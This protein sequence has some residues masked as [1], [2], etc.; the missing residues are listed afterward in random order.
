MCHTLC[1]A[2]GRATEALIHSVLLSPGCYSESMYPTKLH[3]YYG[4]SLLLGFGERAMVG[5]PPQLPALDQEEE[6]RSR[7]GPQVIHFIGPWGVHSA[8]L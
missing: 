1:Q 3:A 2:Q 8:S 6:G 5:R 4:Q 7:K